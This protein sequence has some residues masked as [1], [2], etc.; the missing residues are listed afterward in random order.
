M[1]AAS[2]R[3]RARSHARRDLHRGQPRAFIRARRKRGLPPNTYDI[4][5]VALAQCWVRVKSVGWSFVRGLAFR[6]KSPAVLC[7]EICVCGFASFCV[8]VPTQGPSSGTPL[9]TTPNTL[10]ALTFRRVRKQSAQWL[11]CMAQGAVNR[12]RGVSVPRRDDVGQ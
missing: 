9:Q 1:L 4:H 2:L 5:I 3:H 7:W 8:E 10:P 12:D 11:P 6:P